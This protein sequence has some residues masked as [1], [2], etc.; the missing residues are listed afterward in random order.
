MNSSDFVI[1]VFIVDS[2]QLL[3]VNTDLISSSSSSSS[4]RDHTGGVTW[5][6]A[7]SE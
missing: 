6:V 2:C 4:S 1:L 5:T 3:I 7:Y